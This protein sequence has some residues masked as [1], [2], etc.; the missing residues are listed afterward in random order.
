MTGLVG[1]T[2]TV[3]D[4]LLGYVSS[5]EKDERGDKNIPPKSVAIPRFDSNLLVFI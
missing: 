5:K 4:Q 1:D 2:T 3:Q